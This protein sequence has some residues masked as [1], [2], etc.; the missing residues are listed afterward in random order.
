MVKHKTPGVQPYDLFVKFQDQPIKSTHD[1][2]A[3]IID[4]TSYQRYMGA[5]YN[6]EGDKQNTQHA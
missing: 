4:M 3:R 5:E 1:F 6:I 2:E